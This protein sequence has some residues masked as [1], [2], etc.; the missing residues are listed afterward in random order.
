MSY[1]KMRIQ[2]EAFKVALL[3]AYR[4]LIDIVDVATEFVMKFKNSD[5]LVYTLCYFQIGKNL[6]VLISDLLHV[7]ITI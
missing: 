7:T 4:F 6:F 1:V 5:V 3:L 2:V